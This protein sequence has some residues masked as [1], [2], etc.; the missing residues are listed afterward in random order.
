MNGENL[1]LQSYSKIR[2]LSKRGIVATIYGDNV[3]VKRMS[4]NAKVQS[5]TIGEY[6]LKEF[7]EEDFDAR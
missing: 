5:R 7:I 6:S 4:K 2:E 1:M 3:I